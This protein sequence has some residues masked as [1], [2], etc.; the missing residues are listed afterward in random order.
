MKLIMAT[1]NDNII[2]NKGGMPWP[3]SKVDM[4]RFSNLTRSG[5]SKVI[6]GRKTWESLPAK[7]RPLPGRQNIVLTTDP[8]YRAQG[9][10]IYLDIDKCIDEN[11]DSW[12]IGGAQIYEAFMPHVQEM[13][14]SY[15]TCQTVG[16]TVMPLSYEGFTVTDVQVC[17][18]HVYVR[19]EK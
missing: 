2:G 15:M 17:E 1:A 9:A 18:D 5:N 8:A 11:Q 14:I 4:R 3:H 16:D 10:K 7:F 19:Y 13:H 6:M 12:I